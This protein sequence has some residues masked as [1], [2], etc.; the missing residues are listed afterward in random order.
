MFTRSALRRFQST[1]YINRTMKTFTEILLIRH[2]E[3]EINVETS[4][5][6]GGQCNWAEL[7]DK[8]VEQSRKLGS[9]LAQQSSSFTAVYSSTAVRT[10]QTSR[11]CL[12]AMGIDVRSGDTDIKLDQRL[13]EGDAGDFAG[14]IRSEIYLR[15]DVS[16]EL[17]NDNWNFI[18]GDFVKGESQAGIAVRMKDWLEEVIARYPHGRIIAFT[19]GMAIRCLLTEILNESKPIAYKQSVDNTSVNIIRC[20]DDGEVIVTSRNDTSHLNE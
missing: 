3:S 17:D 1:I 14:K 5:R 4:N 7:S 20:F 16:R 18:P 6:I 2:A 10:Q 19:H 11:H 8:G 12:S 15:S 13:L 9:K